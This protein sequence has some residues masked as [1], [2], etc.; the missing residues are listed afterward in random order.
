MSNEHEPER[1]AKPTASQLSRRML[2]AGA[3]AGAAGVIGLAATG[4]A[5]Q[6]HPAGEPDWEATEQA[7][8]DIVRAMREDPEKYQAVRREVIDSGSH[9]EQ[10]DEL[11]EFATTEH[12]LAALMPAGT[13]L[14]VT[15]TV[16][17]TTILIPNSAY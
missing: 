1:Q 7:L 2:I 16:T 8:L 13:Q 10:I 5:A 15:V 14:A 6:A 4:S 12:E 17:V 9:E 3:G 11:F